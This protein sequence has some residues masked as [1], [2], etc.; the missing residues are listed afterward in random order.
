MCILP[1]L[2][3]RGKIPKIHPSCYVSSRATIAGDVTI[4][5]ESNIWPNAVIRGD[6]NKVVIGVRASIQDCCVLHEDWNSPLIVG[7]RVVIGHGA[8]LHG[9]TIGSDAVIGIRAVVL[10]G[11]KVGDWTIIAAGSV[12]TENVEIPPRSLAVGVPAKVLKEL[13]LEQIERI[14]KGNESYVHLGNEYRKIE[15]RT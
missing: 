4:G 8:V 1:I 3:F 7:D 10:N 11:A 15:G 12:V 2:E 6:W 5:E 9:C 13:N 14:R